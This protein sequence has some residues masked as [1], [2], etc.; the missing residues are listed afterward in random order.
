[1]PR[2]KIQRFFFFF[3]LVFRDKFREFKA[4]FATVMIEIF[5]LLNYVR[6]LEAH[7]MSLSPFLNWRDSSQNPGFYLVLCQ[8][9]VKPSVTIMKKHGPSSQK[10]ESRQGN[11]ASSCEAGQMT[12][13]LTCLDKDFG[14]PPC[15]VRLCGKKIFLVLTFYMNAIW[16]HYHILRYR[17]FDK[18][19]NFP[20]VRIFVFL[21]G[22]LVCVCWGGGS[23]LAFETGCCLLVPTD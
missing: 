22:G 19:V 7:A 9:Y 6:L 12:Y 13:V 18:K 21:F 16:I 8:D 4:I 17:A 20:L 10:R 2:P 15:V 14:G 1:M 11:C 5:C 23:L 3:F